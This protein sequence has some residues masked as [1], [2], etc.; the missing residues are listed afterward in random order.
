MNIKPALVLLIVILPLGILSFSIAKAATIEILPLI[1]SGPLDISPYGDPGGIAWDGE[2]LWGAFYTEKGTV[3]YEVDPQTG[4]LGTGFGLYRQTRL[5]T[6][7][8]QNFV[9]C[10]SEVVWEINKEGKEVAHYVLPG[11][12][13]HNV[14]NIAWDD[15]TPGG[16]YL[17]IMQ[18]SGV[19]YQARLTDPLAI[20]REYNLQAS[21]ETTNFYYMGFAYDGQN[22]WIRANDWRNAAQKLLKIN[23]LD[24]SM[25]QSYPLQAPLGQLWSNNLTVDRESPGGPYLYFS[26]MSQTG[27]R[28]YKLGTNAEIWQVIFMPVVAQNSYF[29]YTDTP[30]YQ[31]YP[32]PPWLTATPY[33]PIYTATPTMTRTRTL[34][35][36]SVFTQIP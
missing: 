12:L 23:P 4:A 25:L 2:H 1:E 24:G 33:H 11:E 19:L 30:D 21:L 8:G 34:A 5:L 27:Y 22:L 6:W 3:I 26:A 10:S 32:P 9:T 14:S 15:Q 31:S 16:P 35:P 29:R 28:W 36:T 13:L 17:W 20:E 18:Y 7:N